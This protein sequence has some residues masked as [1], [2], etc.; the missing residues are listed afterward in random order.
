MF[1]VFD[2]RPRSRNLS[3]LKMALIEFA[4][5]LPDGMQNCV[6]II[7][8]VFVLY[9]S[10]R[11]WR[12][13]I[14]PA[15][16]P[17]RPRALPYLVP[18]KYLIICLFRHSGHFINKRYVSLWACHINGH[19]CRR[20]IYSWEVRSCLCQCSLTWRTPSQGLL[21]S[22]RFHA[23]VTHVLSVS[24]NTSETPERSSWSQSWAR[25]CTS[26]PRPVM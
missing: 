16:N 23:W 24:E 13:S 5:A 11:V 3:L 12:F 19:Q 7:V 25:R 6:P 1:R 22:E 8:T 15:L 9:L 2:L 10:W 21:H 18:C 4:S 26:P 20:N 14:S 17:S